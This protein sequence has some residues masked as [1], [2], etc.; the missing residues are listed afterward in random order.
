MN[1]YEAIKG[2]GELVIGNE[3]ADKYSITRAGTIWRLIGIADEDDEVIKIIQENG[4]GVTFEVDMKCFD[5]VVKKQY[6]NYNSMGR[7]NNY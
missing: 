7:A 2:I 3:L 5:F 4:C 1:Y 6:R